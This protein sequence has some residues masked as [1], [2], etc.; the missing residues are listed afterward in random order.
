MPSDGTISVFDAIVATPASEST[1][2]KLDALVRHE[3]FWLDTIF[4]TDAVHCSTNILGGRLSFEN[5]KAR[6]P[7]GIMVDDNI[8][9]PTVW[10]LL[11]HRE[12]NP[13]TP[14]AVGCWHFG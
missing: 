4:G 8:N 9:P 3:I 11:W 2:I 10:K 7:P 13:R 12:R 5:R 6:D 1:G 14:E